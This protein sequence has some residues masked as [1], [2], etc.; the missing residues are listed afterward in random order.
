MFKNIL[1]PIDGSSMSY[2]P[3]AAAIDMAK[4]QH[5]SLVLVSVAAPRLFNASD[6]EAL[7]DG[8]IVETQNAGMAQSA[9]AE[10]VEAAS[11]AG[12]PCEPVVVQSSVACDEITT[13]AKQKNCDAIFMATRGKMGL[14]DAIFDESTTLQVLQK[15]TVPVLVF[16]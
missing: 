14:L 9:L 3:V 7:H 4:A 8:E 11:R 16:P 1:I 10:A 2:R 15:S 6:K 13:I 12:V 5:G